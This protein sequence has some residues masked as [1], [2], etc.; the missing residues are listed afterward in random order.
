MGR[1]CLVIFI[2]GYLALVY[3]LGIW[4]ETGPDAELEIAPQVPKSIV[5]ELPPGP[6]N[7]RN[8]EGDFIRLESGDI[9]YV[10]TS[11]YGVS[12]DDHASARLVSR[13]SRNYGATWSDKDSL[14]I[15]NEGRLN[16]MSV[17]LLRLRDHSI[18]L[19]YLVKENPG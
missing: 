10:Y 13:V 18:A 16:V 8:S 17:S 2:I 7:P 15:E 14:V 12:G 5:L 11:Y 1:P 4:G 9:L 6:D 19:F 3:T